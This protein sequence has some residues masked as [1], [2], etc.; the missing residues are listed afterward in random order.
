MTSSNPHMPD[1]STEWLRTR[2]AEL[3]GASA[4]LAETDNQRKLYQQLV[5][6]S[7][8]LMCTHD[9]Q[10]VLLS[11]NRAAAAS[12]GYLPQEG[13]GR[14]LKEFL[15]EQYQPEFDAY[16]ERIR[17][18]RV[19]SGYMRLVAKGGE[20]RV[21]MYRNATYEE[22]AKPA[23]V[24]GHA[25]DVTDRVRAERSLRE[26][27]ENYRQLFE[28]APVGCYEMD[29]AG[30][31][32]RV[33]RA[34]TELLGWSAA[35]MVGRHVG[36]FVT[37]AEREKYGA[38]LSANATGDG[39][40]YLLSFIANNGAPIVL[41]V[42]QNSIRNAVGEIKGMRCAAMITRERVIMADHSGE[43]M[44]AQQ[45]AQQFAYVVSHDL[46]APLRQ[47]TST[48]RLLGDTYES[49]LDQE[50]RELLALSLG[51]L[52]RMCALT[53]DL[54]R[55]SIISNAESR[56][57]QIVDTGAALKASLLNLRGSITESGAKIQY[58]E[59]P[60][61]LADF[62]GIIQVFQNL[63][64]N[65]IKYRADRTPEIH[66]T[67][68][69]QGGEWVFAVRDNGIGISEQYW[70]RIFEPF[71]RLHGKEYPGT[72]I[73]LSI[74]QRILERNGGK[75]WLDSK[76]GEGSTFFFTIPH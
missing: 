61:V 72:G 54:L 75:I 60:A 16:L 58:D 8:G 11:V 42:F 4:L 23:I 29:R 14:N 24:L 57:V 56:P 25:L 43:L 48:I 6:H 55:Y 50:A 26:S 20:E 53:D 12:L 52:E 59:M 64:S 2:V 41:Q 39:R 13:I 71:K 44:R 66:I 10:G 37:A 76:R 73:G 15:A 45:E 36:E 49:R 33:N 1:P 46:Q 74:C 32:K 63:I 28:E 22:T 68:R 38:D 70:K 62:E 67:V 21:W 40:R 47:V 35:E 30:I 17:Q 19:D 7:L 18:R 9:L 34:L 5:E 31:L 3:E 65:A 69:D 51:G 27:E